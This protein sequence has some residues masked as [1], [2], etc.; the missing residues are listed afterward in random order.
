M[1][2]IEIKTIPDKEQR[3]DTVGDYWKKDGVDEIRVSSISNR[4]YEFLIAIHEMIEQ[5]LCESAG[6]T[7]EEITKFDLEYE[8]KRKKG[9]AS[10]PGEDTYAPYRK[11][12]MFAEKM[13]RLMAQECGIDWDEYIKYSNRFYEKRLD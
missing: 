6:I 13:E 7:D 5:F 3:Y 4:Q 8:A 10:E 11:Q 2:N 12:H 1:L 9:D